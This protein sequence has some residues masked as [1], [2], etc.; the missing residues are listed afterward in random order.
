MLEK[1]PGAYTYLHDPMCTVPWTIFLT[2]RLG[3]EVTM[4]AAGSKAP[5]F[6]LAASTGTTVSLSDYRGKW[7]VVYFYP[8]DDTPGCT[9]EAREF[10]ELVDVFT[11]KDAVILG[12]STDSVESHCRFREKHSLSIPLLSD[13]DHHAI[14]PYGAWG[15]KNNDGKIS[16][17]L[18]RT[19]VLIAPDATIA[20]IWNKVNAAGH[21]QDVL[22]ELT[23]QQGK[24]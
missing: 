19:T 9:I 24:Q 11:R 13:P 3:K 21:A 8:R 2:R 17:G 1:V 4:L 15:E 6:A 23:V 10:S 20:R 14:E 22:T 16:Y 12:I 18:I 7:V 5:P